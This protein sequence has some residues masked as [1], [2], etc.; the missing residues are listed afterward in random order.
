MTKFQNTLPTVVGGNAIGTEEL[1]TYEGCGSVVKKRAR[2][3]VAAGP[4]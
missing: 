4:H 2:E 1:I 3:Q